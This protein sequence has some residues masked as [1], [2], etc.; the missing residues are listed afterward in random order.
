VKGWKDIKIMGKL[1]I[2]FGTVMFLLVVVSIWTFIGI[3]TIVENA[4]EVIMGNQLN[5][6]LAQ[7]EVDHL[8]WANDVNRLLT[9]DEVVE[10]SVE[11]DD[12]QCAF[13]KWLY[14]PEREAAQS[15]M[16][17]LAALFKS[18]E[19][20]HMHLHQSAAEI[21]EVFIQADNELPAKISQR[22]I[23]HLTWASSIRDSLLL[24]EKRLSVELNHNN[25]NLGRWVISPEG[26]SLYNMKSPEFQAIWDEMLIDHKALHNSAVQ[27]NNM[28]SG[29]QSNSQKF[30]KR[31]VLPHLNNTIAGLDDLKDIAE[32][33]IQ[34]MG[35]A[36]DIYSKKTSP[37][38]SEVQRL[39][40]EIRSSAA[41][42]IMTDTQ[43][44]KA[45][46]L[47]RQMI[48]IISIIAVAVAIILALVIAKGI[49][50][51]MTKGINFAVS[52]SQGD[53]TATIDM[54]QEDE[55]GK[56]ADALKV[57]RNSLNHVVSEVLISSNNVSSGSQQLS[58]TS[59]QLSQGAT[60]QASS[61]EE[62]SSSME[63][64]MSNIE[65]SSE[66]AHLTEQIANKA[67]L[68]IEE[69]GHAVLETVEAMKNIAEKISIIQNIASQTNML[70]LNAAIEAARAGE[71][72]KGFA[73]VAA[74]VGKLAASSKKAAEEISTLTISSVSQANS[75]G[76]LMEELVPQIKNTASL[77]QEISA[78]NKEQRSG[79]EQITQAVTQLD[80]VVQQNASAAEES[81][82]MAEELSAQANH[83]SQLIG[84]FKL[85]E[86]AGLNPEGINLLE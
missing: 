24:G 85:D 58:S 43:M 57:M 48:L 65:Q 46:Q 20:P 68:Q 79:A 34:Q 61:A 18:I 2:G 8:N 67:A 25:C 71:H 19:E 51:A 49:T 56:L 53:L 60:E 63:E 37:S 33:E 23:E 75:S 16:P 59:Q 82:A 39:L 81:A 29:S 74:E 22:E 5:G 69:G 72:G 55:I 17:S 6:N 86:Q 52:L 4:K 31:S 70:S 11:L 38:L 76:K 28:M 13:G 73:V 83:L 66:N 80:T 47:T 9:D 14:G 77:I 44:L 41:A 1:L 45:A 10:L 15:L 35:K 42:L 84:F 12:H 54:S 30:F 3:S 7:K 50:G 62:V 78:S 27:L 26:Q 21:E 40:N 32:E 36:F 64:M